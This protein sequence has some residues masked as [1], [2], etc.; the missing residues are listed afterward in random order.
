[1]IGD[2]AEREDEIAD[3]TL[4]VVGL[5]DIGGRLARLAKAF[6]CV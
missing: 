4:L 3:K 1:M 5:G 2:P 6:D